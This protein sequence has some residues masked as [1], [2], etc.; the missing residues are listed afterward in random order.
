MLRQ[1]ENA[2]AYVGIP[3]KILSNFWTN[4]TQNFGPS[5]GFRVWAFILQCLTVI[6]KRMM[7][8]FLSQT[9]TGM[10]VQRNGDL[11]EPSYFVHVTNSVVRVCRLPDW[12]AILLKKNKCH[13]TV[14]SQLQF[15][16]DVFE[17]MVSSSTRCSKKCE[18][19]WKRIAQSWSQ[20]NQQNLPCW[21]EKNRN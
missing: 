19:V 3:L 14:T 18:Q 7:V 5:S 6:L 21:V 13:W 9:V 1:S 15:L 17:L 16:H 2:A 12:H 8:S 20:V 11:F 10:N 4:F